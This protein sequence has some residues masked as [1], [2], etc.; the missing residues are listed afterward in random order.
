M[1]EATSL[2]LAL[3]VSCSD[4]ASDPRL[5]QVTLPLTTVAPRTASF[6]AAISRRTVLW[7]EE[8]DA[9]AATAGCLLELQEA[10]GKAAAAATLEAAGTGAGC[11]TLLLLLLELATVLAGRW[12]A[13]LL[14]RGT[15]TA[16]WGVVAAAVSG[17]GD[18]GSSSITV[19]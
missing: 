14:S 11:T 1:P 9:A 16:S 18:I 7:D 6:R 19:T 12:V 4:T 15:V 17:D 2:S 13:W 8:A 10:T 3:V 5:L